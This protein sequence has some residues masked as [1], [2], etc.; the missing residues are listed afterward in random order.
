MPSV[1]VIGS[2]F[3]TRKPL[4]LAISAS[5]AGVGSLIFPAVVQYLTPEVGFESAVRYQAIIALVF[6]ILINLLLQ[7]R[8][9]PRVSG[10]LVEWAAFRELPYVLFA[11]GCFLFFWVLYFCFFYINTFA[12]SLGL[13]PTHAGPLQ[14][15]VNSTGLPA[16]PLLGWLASHHTGPINAFL[17]SLASLGLLLFCWIPIKPVPGLYAW[18]VIYGISTGCAQGIF[19]GALASLSRDPSKLGTRF[20]MVC[21]LLAFASLAGPPTAGGLIEV[22]GGRWAGAQVWA[23]A[24]T[25]LGVLC[26]WFARVRVVGWNPRVK[27]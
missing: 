6:A 4:A 13:T 1:F 3:G 12:S 9:A 11:I 25:M 20:G 2:Y 17:V 16:R 5:G 8:L 24:V 27:I 18:S 15:L 22:D 14:L 21:T 10:P 26:C 7:P 19:V 23:G